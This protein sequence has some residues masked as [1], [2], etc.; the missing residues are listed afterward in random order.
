SPLPRRAATP[1]PDP[2]IRS[3]DRGA[4]AAARDPAPRSRGAHPP[5]RTPPSTRSTCGAVPGDVL[6]ADPCHAGATAGEVR[7][8]A[9]RVS[10]TASSLSIVHRTVVYS[11]WQGDRSGGVGA[12][13]IW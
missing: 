7:G 8:G 5:P 4:T 3:S 13:M 9:E 10:G 1:D 6:G 12:T 11:P 2:S